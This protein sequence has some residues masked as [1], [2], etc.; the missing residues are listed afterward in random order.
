MGS[1]SFHLGSERT[2]IPLLFNGEMEEAVIPMW[3]QSQSHDIWI[4]IISIHSWNSK[5]CLN[6]VTNKNKLIQL[7]MRE[8][9]K[10][11]DIQ[12]RSI[13]I[14][15]FLYKQSTN[16]WCLIYYM[17]FQLITHKQLIIQNLMGKDDWQSCD[18]AT[19]WNQLNRY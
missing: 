4:G 10:A 2:T 3:T 1:N 19:E 6:Y 5:D 15:Y 7:R 18:I 8:T 14:N 16:Q 12:C 11:T 9:N 17:G 13:G